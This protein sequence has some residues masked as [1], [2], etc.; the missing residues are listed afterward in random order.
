MCT[1]C[2]FRDHKWRLNLCGERPARKQSNGKRELFDTL[3]ET[4]KFFI[5][6]TVSVTFINT[7]I[8]MLKLLIANRISAATVI[9]RVTAFNYNGNK[10]LFTSSLSLRV[11]STLQ[12]TVSLEDTDMSM[13]LILNEHKQQNCYSQM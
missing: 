5:E 6:P 3:S 7:K 10:L 8:A 4:S 12:G 2:V 13:V 11:V 9:F 1:P